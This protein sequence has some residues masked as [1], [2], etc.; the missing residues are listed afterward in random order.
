M[1]SSGLLLTLTHHHYDHR[2]RIAVIVGSAI[3][4]LTLAT[5]PIRQAIPD[6]AGAQA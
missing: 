6:S 2:D 5:S 1:I 3:T 4:E